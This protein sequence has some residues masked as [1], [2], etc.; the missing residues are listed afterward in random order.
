[1]SGRYGVKEIFNTLQGEGIR[2]GTRA[3][4]LRFTGCNLWDGHPLHR[5]QG[6]G[7]CAQWCDTDFM[8]GKVLDTEQLLAQMD[9]EWPLGNDGDRWCVLTGGEPALQLDVALVDA[10]HGAGWKVAIET[11]GTKNTEAVRACDH[12]CVSPKLGSVVLVEAANE[13]KVVV[14]GAMPPR[15]GWTTEQLEEVERS[16]LADYYFVNPMDPPLVPDQVGL[17][18]LRA[19]RDG[20]VDVDE[21]SEALGTAFF[22]HGLKRAHDFVMSHPRWRLGSQHHKSWGVP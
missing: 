2:A 19:A 14:P 5:D 10:L 11:N 12:I 21:E 13:V 16:I 20:T 18:V 17:T 22:Q 3:V 6:Q 4:F 15:A 7:A 8:K 9:A 1:M